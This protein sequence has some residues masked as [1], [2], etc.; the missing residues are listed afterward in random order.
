MS[1]IITRLG[2]A[3]RR[4]FT[5]LLATL[6]ALPLGATLAMSPAQAHPGHE[7]TAPFNALIF[8]K[9]AGFRHGSIGAGVAAIQQLGADHG[10]TVD[11]TENAG[12]FTDANLAQYDV[13]IWLSTTGDVL[14]NAQQA[15][16]ERYIEGGGGYAG[17]HAASDTEYDWPWYGEL[18]GSYFKGHPA[19]QD[20]TVKVEDPAHPSTSGMAPLWNRFDEWY[21][22]QSNPRGDVHVLASL[23]ETSY[24]GGD[25]GV[26]HPISWCQ[27]YE[28]GRSW[29]TGMGH[30]N[31]SFADPQF[32]DHVLGG[33]RT[34]AGVQPADCAATLSES[35]EKVT[36]DDNTANPMELVIADD[37][38]VVYVD[39]NG[40]VKVIAPNGNVS[41]AGTLNV[42]TGQEFGLL[43]I[44]LDPDFATNNQLYLYYSPVGAGP[45]DRVSRFTME[46]NTLDMASEEVVLTLDVQRDQC[47]HAGGALEFDNDG[48]LY[49]A[50]GDNS[51]PFASS[52]Y[53]PIDERDG[54]S[55]WDAQ[56]SSANT[57]SLS[58][59]VLRITPQD[60]GTYTVP[61][62]NLF[63]PGTAQTR[64]EIFAMG[65]RNPFRI[66]LD[67]QTGN[68]LVADYGPDAGSSD[69]ERGPDGRVE[70]NI[71]AEPGFYGWPYCVGDNTPYRDFDFATSTSGPAFDC[72][73]PTN[74]S[75]NNTGLTSLPAA[76]P[77]TMWQGK[78][79]TGVPE[80]GGSGAPMTSGSY[81]FD[82]DLESDRKWPAYYDGKAI[83][84]D[85]NNSR[86]FAVQMNQDRTDYTDVNR[87][88]EEMP[89]TR[90]HALQF[91]PDGA[92]YMIEWGSGFGGNNA[93]SGI[94]RIDYVQGNRAPIARA[95][96][97]VTSGPAPLT[98][99]FD[100]SGS[101]DPDGSPLTYAWDFD[102][103]GTTD[104]TEAT[105]E[106]TYTVVGDYTARLTVTDAD[107]R[108]AVSNI[109]I[110]VGNTAPV[111]ELV[112]P[113]D[114]GF[115]EFGDTIRYEVEVTD[116]EDTTIDCDDVVVQPALGHDEH[117]H[118]YEQYTGCS[119]S[120]PLPGDEGHVG[121]DIFGTVTAT[122][123]DNGAPGASSLTGQDTVVLHTKRTEAEF[124]DSTGRLAGS[125]SA[126]DAGVI[127]ETTGDTQGGGQNVGYIEPGDWFGW[128]VMNLTAID[129]ITMRAASNPAAGATFEVRTGDPDTGPTVATIQ[130]PRTGGWQQYQNFS[131][132]PT[133]PTTTVSGP[134]YFVETRGGANIN[135]IDFEGRGVTDNQRPDLTLEADN[136]TGDGPLEVSFSAAA[137][138]P[139]GDDPITYTWVFGDGATE[140][141]G[142]SGQTTHT[143]TEP[144]TYT[145]RVTATDARGAT[146]SQQVTVRVFEELVDC[147][148]GRS[149]DFLGSSLDT[150]R[151]DSIVRPDDTMTVS[152]GQL[153]IP[154][155]ATDIY[156]ANGSA[157]PN[158][159][160][161]HLPG[162]AFE[163]T[164]KLT[165]P[166]RRQYQQAGLIIYGDDN[167]YLKMVMQ[168]RTQTPDAAARV[169]QFLTEINGSASETNTG[170]IGADF[171]DT[172]W[173]RVSSDNGLDVTASYSVDG[174]DWVTMSG[175]RSIAGINEPRVGVFG[176]ANNAAALPITADFDYFTISPDD[177]ATP[178][179]DDTTAPT[180][181]VSTDPSEPDGANG[182][183]TS[184]VTVSAT[185]EDES[186]G[187][188]TLEVRL[189]DGE[190][191]AYDGAVEI[192]D[193]GEHVVR[194]RATDAAG[195]VT[196][197]EQVVD[198]DATAPTIAVSGLQDGATLGV[199]AAREVTVTADDATSGID[200]LVVTLDGEE[201]DS[202]VGVDAVELLSG[203]HTLVA[204][205]TDLAG[206]TTTRTITFEV[207]A[208]YDGG[209]A[210]IDRLESD[211]LISAKQAK[212]L[213]SRLLSAQKHFVT[214]KTA[215]AHKELDKFAQ[216]AGGVTDATARAALVDLADELKQL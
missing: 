176:L 54:R 29:Y 169:F 146:A 210:L 113:L 1:R 17:I 212:D 203:E 48:N 109:D 195:N 164:T 120:F 202:P 11:A 104:A 135:W 92:L 4:G 179:G 58:G 59:K 126:G 18:V 85:W 183:F 93:N 153:H 101:T 196:E 204:T 75:P 171:P 83:W 181:E 56:R 23:D 114:G 64:P 86:L 10:F 112:L 20:A 5:L 80:I 124:F 187:D 165:L 166:A 49:I 132:S 208:S 207:V 159:V 99:Q 199:A 53:A 95:T 33:I 90:P 201:V 216:T 152:D 147:F 55:A 205:A 34:A 180:L 98:V 38:R 30:T 16:F 15:A 94:Y 72:G 7:E 194:F 62:G 63:A 198:L 211:G 172:F 163:V 43:G 46:G 142:E 162:G 77:A 84:A 131:A 116:A 102:G 133:G 70:W 157:T 170:G 167:N 127:R 27:D 200:S 182:W 154:L 139:D 155:T 6:V 111:V 37:G 35:F 57:N 21:N 67:E 60:D 158:I 148:T 19:Q 209:F 168:G 79:S 31:E 137:T 193:D 69:P 26:E 134:L 28:G 144:G 66:G 71:V 108:T 8:S 12:A 156:G 188:V 213:Q 143:Y 61:D 118:G 106:H 13:V 65:F 14:D 96:A 173:V 73:A 50:T 45:V 149:D 32:L 88:L 177:T 89:L 130:I 121:A 160:L 110:V 91:G 39:R 150:D 214:G 215:N 185:A 103:D 97:D 9:T 178:C 76:I 78:S 47:C 125:T 174:R 119:G 122:Y 115:F 141:T 206:N 52:G 191:T 42:Y 82:P 197:D 44:A 117:A 136:T 161:Q 40:D 128:D 186:A 105:A 140:D 175:T 24:T 189:D 81:A 41:T 184:A 2:A 192:T 25:M 151:W 145:A 68:I 129:Q 123:R 100:G 3:T 138:D 51:N 74:D 36:L 22:Y 190:W 107:D 87:F